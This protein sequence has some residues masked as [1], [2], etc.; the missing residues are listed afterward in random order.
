MWKTY[1]IQNG[2]FSLW[3]SEFLLLN[4]F[5]F[6][7][8]SVKTIFSLL[9]QL[10]FTEVISKIWLIHS[11]LFVAILIGQISLIISRFWLIQV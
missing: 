1:N 4:Q 8:S 5:I 11:N 9:N 7:D 10:L 3:M 2:G 6:T